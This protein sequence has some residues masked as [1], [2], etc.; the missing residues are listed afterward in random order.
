MCRNKPSVAKLLPLEAKKKIYVV[1]TDHN[2]TISPNISHWYD[3]DDESS[4]HTTNSG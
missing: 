2:K 1:Q 3:D 4:N